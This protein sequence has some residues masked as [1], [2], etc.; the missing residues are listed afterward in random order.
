MGKILRDLWIL[1]KDGLT[2]FSRVIDPN[3]CPQL[4]GGL[5]SAL[6]TFA[7]SLSEGGISNFELSSIRFTIEKKNHFIF[8]ANSSNDIKTK[9]VMNELKKISKIF[10]KV[11]PEEVVKNWSKNVKLFAKFEEHI[12]DSLEEVI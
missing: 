12:I 8:V 5:M 7:E 2:I 6:N 11:Y 3:I 4:F 1:T 10:F 9:K